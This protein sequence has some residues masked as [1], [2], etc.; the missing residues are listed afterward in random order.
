MK[1]AAS[2]VLCLGIAAV[3]LAGAHETFVNFESGPVRPLAIS[4]DGRFLY[5]CNTPDNRLEVFRVEEANLSRAGEVRVG[6][7]PVAVAAGPG[8]LVYVVNH[9]SDSV[10]VVD[11]SRPERPVV[12]RTLQ[13]GDEPRDVVLAG[14]NRDR[15]LVTAA[16]RGQNRPGDAALTTP[17]VGRAD[18]WVFDLDD[19]EAAPGIVTLF[20]D[21]PRGLAVSPD[22]RRVYAGIFHSG[23]RSTVLGELA[24]SPEPVANFLMGDGFT[25]LGLPPPRTNVQGI[26]GPSTSLIVRSVDGRWLDGVGRD[27]TPR[28]RFDLPDHDVF[29]LDM[30]EDTPRVID[31]F[32]GVGTILFNLDVN[33]RDGRVAVSNLESRNHVRFEPELV[34][35][36][37]E[38]RV[39][40][41]G[42]GSVTPVHLNGHLD[43]SEPF[44]PEAERARSV[45]MPL[46]LQ[47]SS[48]GR[49]LYLVAFGSATLAV[50]DEQGAVLERIAVGG[51]PSGLALDEARQQAYVLNRFDLSISL[52]DLG[53]GRE[54]RR[55]PL[56]FNPEPEVIR[57]G[58]PLLY[59]ASNSAYGDQS[60]ATCHVFGDLD[61]LAWDLGDPDGLVESNP[62]EQVPVQ[63]N[64]LRDFHPLKGPMTTQSLRGM[65]GAGAMHWRGDR[66]GG[67]AAPFD[68]MEAFLQFRPAFEGLLGLERELP[69]PEMRAFGEFILTVVYPPN[70]IA[71][72]D[73]SLTLEQR[74]GREIFDSSGF[75]LGTGGD[76]DP[77]ESCHTLPLGT[78]GLA[79]FEGLDQDMKVPHLRNLYQKLG[80]FGTSLPRIVRAQGLIPQL[81]DRPTP[82]LGD[83]IRGFGFLHDGSI[84]NLFDFFL[85]PLM[86]FTFL[87]EPGRSGQQKVRELEA[88]LL[89]FPTGLAPAV[90]QQ[91]T[92]DSRLDP[93]GLARLE[94][95]RS[96]AEAGDGNLVL[97]GLWRGSQRSFLYQEGR[98][99]DALFQSDRR[100]ETATWGQM[101]ARLEA[102]EALLTA[103]LTPP[104]SGVRIGLDR[105]EDGVFDADERRVGRPRA[106]R[107]RP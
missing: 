62:L 46:Q 81:Q 78:A 92:L 32:Q 27:W 47:Y 69:E 68:E 80:M 85:F 83:Q 64:G 21:T 55:I 43:F 107:P 82:H 18:L 53:R 86:P 67:A 99:A 93:E 84:P 20:G 103:L 63:D 15:L 97:S 26:E 94:L 11:A 75:R 39:T 19:L 73:G 36:I 96:R 34:G 52:V 104:G 70:P 88:F 87:D 51:G 57:A 58:R 22:G 13:T 10:S 45:A 2:F 23:N 76:G 12:V 38:N 50:L 9:L 48:D 16:R 49:R 102:G 90:G 31:F 44:A 105:D 42:P 65:R 74:A 79:S 60:C 77:C 91:V 29:V 59:D 14:A 95:L 56:R 30:E 3:P 5:A 7:E 35:R 17:G 40:F 100:L 41:L 37:A 98:G 71:N 28:V 1:R 24:V 101:R 25:G 4:P 61:S 33:P 8:G 106:W 89:A 6:L 66:N 54:V 72:L